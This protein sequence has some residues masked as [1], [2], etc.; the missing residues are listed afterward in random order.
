MR[1]NLANVTVTNWSKD[2]LLTLNTTQQRKLTRAIALSREMTKVSLRLLQD[3]RRKLQVKEID[4]QM[5]KDLFASGEVVKEALERYFGITKASATFTADLTTIIAKLETTEA[6]LRAAFDIVVGNIHDWDD[7][8]DGVR[9]AFAQVTAG[10][11]RAAVAELKFIRTGTEG[12]V[13]PPANAQRRIHLNVSSINDEPEDLIT[14]IIVHEATHKFAGTVDVAY[15]WD[16]L[17]H[18]AGGYANL[19]NNADSYAWACRRIWKRK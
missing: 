5:A 15:K 3:Y 13:G 19:T 14:R 7:V 8:R 4:A 1:L 17:K 2:P 18:N 6:G 10:R 12:W 16:S 9:D 11:F